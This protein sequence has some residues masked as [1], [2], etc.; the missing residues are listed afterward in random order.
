MAAKGKI[1]RKIRPTKK[2]GTVHGNKR[3]QL[4]ML[5]GMVWIKRIATDCCQW[6]INSRGEGKGWS[7]YSTL[8]GECKKNGWYKGCDKRRRNSSCQDPFPVEKDSFESFMRA[9]LEISYPWIP[10]WLCQRTLHPVFRHAEWHAFSCP[11]C[12]SF[13][14]SLSLYHIIC[15]QPKL[16]VSI[17]M[18]WAG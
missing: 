18:S 10:A 12:F 14:Q 9:E 2:K 1:R 6:D 7:L 17:Y 4:G 16:I 5:S 11:M 15:I 8:V 3:Y 13:R